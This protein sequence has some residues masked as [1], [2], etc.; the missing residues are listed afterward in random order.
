MGPYHTIQQQNIFSAH[1]GGSDMSYG[2]IT[3]GS[4]SGYHSA[5]SSPDASSNHSNRHSRLFEPKLSGELSSS[6]LSQTPP[7]P[8]PRTTSIRQ[9]I[10]SGVTTLL[11]IS[12]R[13]SVS[14]T[15]SFQDSSFATP[16]QQPPLSGTPVVMRNNSNISA[17]EGYFCPS[18]NSPL[19][20][21]SAH[22]S[23]SANHTHI[24]QSPATRL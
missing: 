10:D 7:P 23:N 14:S 16:P 17:T 2:T 11:Q 12:Q 13:S 4:S 24:T 22:S 21:K 3:G 8:I 5:Y 9:S 19:L 15:S 6:D 20:N 18:D 1:H